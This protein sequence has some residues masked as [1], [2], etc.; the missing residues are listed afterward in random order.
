MKYII[1]VP[2]GM[3][4][5]KYKELDGRTPMEY[6]NTPAM[7]S[8][9]E[10][11]IMGV[12]RT[13]PAGFSPG[14]DIANLSIMGYDPR[15]YHRGRSPLEA[16]SIGIEPG[17]DDVI[18]RCNLVTL[19]N[20]SDYREKAMIDYSAGEIST[21]DSAMLIEYLKSGL[22]TE[23]IRFYSGVSYRNIMVWKGG[24]Y[25]TKL[26]P[27]HDILE[28]RIAPYLP[29]GTGSKIMLELMEQSSRMLQVHPLNRSRMDRGYR[30]ANSIWLWGQGKKPYLANF[31]DKYGLR[32]SV[33]SAVDL[34]RGIGICAGLEVV[35]VDGITGTI[36]TNLSGKAK[37]AADEL[38][39]G[40]DFVY[41]HIEAP[42]E[43]SHQ[44]SLKDKIRAI[45]MIDREVVGYIQKVMDKS[46]QDYRIMVLPDHYTPVRLRTHTSKRVPFLIFD[47]TGSKITE[48]GK[49]PGF[50]EKAAAAAGIIIDRG[51]LLI[52]VLLQNKTLEEIKKH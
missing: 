50:S 23:D 5:Y 38:L 28:K 33:I 16:I 18:F 45:E 1:I 12:A 6:A 17:E 22:E 47:S 51:H 49:I 11:G 13:V 29:S 27:P 52:D 26:T 15:V 36:D 43:C 34:I 8:L 39:A 2:D 30:P 21:E 42:D 25:K 40:K 32:G 9:S 3:A 14:S 37:A 10:S 19:S 46:G 20:E 41:V 4:D 31:Y 7:D 48:N 24:P 35:E 44:G